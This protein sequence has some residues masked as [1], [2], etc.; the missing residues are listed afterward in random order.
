MHAPKTA[1]D[2]KRHELSVITQ[3][4][5]DLDLNV[6]NGG[7]IM[8]LPFTYLA[9]YIIGTFEFGEVKILSRS[10]NDIR[11]SNF[12]WMSTSQDI[13]TETNQSQTR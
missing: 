9:I 4:D 7:Y 3:N 11:K 12:A 2:S 1:N 5:N 8:K 6:I 10:W 13:Q